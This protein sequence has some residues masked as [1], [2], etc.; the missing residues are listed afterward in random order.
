MVKRDR[1]LIPKTED[2]MKNTDEV[3]DKEDSS[4]SKPSL[5]KKVKHLEDKLT[6][7]DDVFGK[8]E[9]PIDLGDMCIIKCIFTNKPV[10]CCKNG[11]HP[12]IYLC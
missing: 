3:K 5:K 8:L 2:K 4:I 1:N 11:F 12:N 9:C 6:E 7:H 10:Y